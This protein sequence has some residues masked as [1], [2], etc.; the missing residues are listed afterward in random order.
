MSL[1]IFGYYCVALHCHIL[2]FDHFLQVI[3][4]IKSGNEVCG[5]EKIEEICSLVAKLVANERLAEPKGVSCKCLHTH[6]GF[7]HAF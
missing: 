4:V 2:F 1:T 6:L 5:E 7:P 3:P